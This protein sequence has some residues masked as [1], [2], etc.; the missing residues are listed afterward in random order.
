M[1]LSGREGVGC[2]IEVGEAG[3]LVANM[4]EGAVR[5]GFFQKLKHE[6]ASDEGEDNDQS[7]AEASL[8]LSKTVD[9]GS[10]AIP[11]G[12]H[13]ATVWVEGE[14]ALSGMECREGQDTG[15]RFGVVWSAINPHISFPSHAPP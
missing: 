12:E 1:N 3:V 6:G 2:S 7:P 9:D 4:L 5:Q 15:G 13:G 10:S 11:S 8:S 14:S